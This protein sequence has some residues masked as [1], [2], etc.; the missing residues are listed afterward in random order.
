MSVSDFAAEGRRLSRLIDEALDELT[1]QVRAYSLA[2]RDYRKA[3]ALAWIACSGLAK[4]R[5]DEV[6]A[7]TADLRYLRD[8]AEG[9][10]RAALESVRARMAQLSAAQTMSNREQA[11]LKLARTGPEMAP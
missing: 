7:T 3:R 2:E 10:R 6:N 5:E 9:L 8:L 1:A 11:E 4:E